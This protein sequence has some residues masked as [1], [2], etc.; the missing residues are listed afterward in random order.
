M[1]TPTPPE[2]TD[3]QTAELKEFKANLSKSFGMLVQLMAKTPGWAQRSAKDIYEKALPALL[4]RQFRFVV[5]DE[6]DAVSYISWAT[7]SPEVESQL[8]DKDALALSDWQ[9]GDTGLV[10]DIVCQNPQTA[11]ALI[12]KL[13][14]E[15]FA[16][17]PL[18]AM[19]A[20]RGADPQLTEV[21]APPTRQ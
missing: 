1:A 16:D 12:G 14:Q 5:D 9:S 8:A 20:Q 3:A 21:P 18:K 6:G 4:T 15:Q 17:K 19:R 11:A 7:I 10:I 13:K 2:S